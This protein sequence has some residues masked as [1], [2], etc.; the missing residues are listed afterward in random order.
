MK[1]FITKDGK[2]LRRGFTTGSCA[3][4]AAKAATA[5]LLGEKEINTVRLVTPKGTGLD[6]DI[7]DILISDDRVSCAVVKDSGDDP[8]V[9]N[10]IKVYASVEKAVSGIEIDG[11]EGVGRVTRPG[12]DQPVGAAAINSTPRRMIAEAVAEIAKKHGNTDGFIVTISVPEGT[13]IAK[14]TFNGRL[15][16]EG[17]ISILGTTGIVEPMS[18]EAVVETIRTELSVRRAEGRRNILFVP[19][20]YG[21]DFI[22][23]ELGIDPEIAVMTSNFIGDAFDLA[24][25]M[26]FDSALLIGHIG[27]LIKLAGGVKNTHSKYGDR[28]AEI[29]AECAGADEETT[30]AL[31]SSV[32]TDDM[33]DIAEQKGI[34]E[35]T[36][37]TIAEKIGENIKTEK[38]TTGAIAF[39]NKSGKLLATADAESLLRAIRE[40]YKV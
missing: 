8:D 19:G 16:I 17:G 14:K 18:D 7:T 29:F 26:G 27:K 30:K 15:G 11:G 38:M 1:S 10:G 35:K 36:L 13:E 12:L 33:L 31:L 21:A 32:M 2:Q 4:A 34:K 6:L 20:N 24:A 22:R 37:N 28:R 39:S 5:M 9:T 40:E 3:A 23:D 25:E